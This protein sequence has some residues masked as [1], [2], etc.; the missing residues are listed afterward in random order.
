MNTMENLKRSFDSEFERT[1][2][3]MNEFSGCA[4]AGKLFRELMFDKIKIFDTQATGRLTGIFKKINLE[5]DKKRG[6]RDINLSIAKQYLIGQELNKYSHLNNCVDCEDMYY[7]IDFQSMVFKYLKFNAPMGATHARLFV[8]EIG[9]PDFEYNKETKIYEQ[10]TTPYSGIYESEYF[11]VSETYLIAKIRTFV[12][13][14][15]PMVGRSQILIVGVE[16]FQNVGDNY[17]LF[18]VGNA[19]KVINIY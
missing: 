13:Y 9:F 17:Y 19:A 16:F 10:K 14:R 5:S 4:Q 12:N 8:Q 11:D 1:R 6:Y 18:N 2:E 15:Q 7:D 3:N